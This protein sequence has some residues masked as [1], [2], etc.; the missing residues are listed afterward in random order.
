MKLPILGFAFVLFL[1]GT[2][3]PQ[4][5]YAQRSNYFTVPAQAEVLK[6]PWRRTY[7]SVSG[8]SKRKDYVYKGIRA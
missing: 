2:G 5:V 4:F 8:I 1:L 7:L 3:Y 6:L